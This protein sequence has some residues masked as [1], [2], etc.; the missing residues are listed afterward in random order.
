GDAELPAGDAGLPAG[1][2]ELPAGGAELRGGDAG[3][4]AGD[5]ELVAICAPGGVV[6]D[7]ERCSAKNP[8]DGGRLLR[9]FREAPYKA[10]LYFGFEDKDPAMSVSLSFVRDICERFILEL[11]RDN[12]IEFTRQARP[13]SQ[14]VVDG[15]I[16]GV[17]F[18]TGAELVD[19]EWVRA[20]WAGLAGAFELEIGAWDGDAADFLRQ[21]K[22]GLNVAGRIFFHLV[23]NK[24]EEFPFAFMA[25]YSTG[26]K[27]SRRVNHLPLKG[28]LDE[29]RNDHETLL[30][31]LATISRAAER[32]DFLSSLMESGELFSPLRLTAGDAYTFLRET[33][34]YEECGILCRIPNWWKRRGGSVR[35]AVSF[36]AAEEAK[37]GFDA[38]LRCDPALYF[39][40]DEIS[41]DE[42]VALS[43]Q[44][45]GLSFLKGK[46]VEVDQEKIRLAL[47]AYEKA[48][49]LGD[50]TIAEAMRLELGIDAMP[51]MGAEVDLPQLTNEGWRASLRAR[52]AALGRRGGGAAGAG[53]AAAAGEA[54]GAGEK[55][56]ELSPGDGFKAT[57]RHYQQKG[58][59][60]L[61]A[62]RS[63]G[64]GALLA[65]DMGLGKT[66]Q[67]LALLEYLRQNGGFRGLLILPASLVGNWQ[68]EIERFAPEI[69]YAVLHPSQKRT[70]G[71]DTQ[72]FITTYGMALRL[73]ELGDRV[74]D[75]LILDEAQA[76]KNPGA[77][78]TKAIK[79]IKAAFRVA[80]TGTPVENRLSD[81][82]SLFDFLNAG[83][84]GSV[85]EF[86]RYAGT[87]KETGSYG[88]L[89]EA[90]R[91]FIL[92]RL[93]TDKTIISDLPDKIEIKDYA[94]LTKK[95][96][97][98]YVELVEDI[99]AK[100]ARAEDQAG[101]E[102]KGMVLAAIMKFKQICNHPDQYL[103][104]SEYKEAH[105]G[106]FEKLR[107]I[108]ET[109]AEKREKVIVFTQF[110][111]ITAYLADYL[112]GVFHRP[113]LVIHGGTG[114]KKRME[115]VNRFNSEEYV[116][117]MVLSLKAGG[118]GLNLTAA[119][120]VVHFDRW[121]NPAVENQAT[122]R[123]FRI[124]QTKNVM[125]RKFIAKGTI[126]EK[127]DEM[128]ESKLGLA[129]SLLETSGESWVTE[130][131]DA[132]LLSLFSLD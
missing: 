123:A 62:M 88:K 116:P 18:M 75:L 65:D 56:A 38:I 124:G 127:I 76:I 90:I 28:A 35:V 16:A 114:V 22:A 101:I 66:A 44:S 13:P 91:P 103:G 117:F 42:L 80:M 59:L 83:F 24:S 27:G 92:R 71:D 9:A 100:L 15:I 30:K 19:G 115:Y 39:G 96:R 3:L 40:D 119:S 53:A 86:A 49:A 94:G 81:L 52:L 45:A 55:A 64:F 51:S 70:D 99:R 78:Q 34:D 10:L 121:W 130:M 12:E 120:H 43:R 98:L 25:T 4:P 23:E 68:K 118:V 125:V 29:Y 32:S 58:F 7:E 1:D 57:L 31:L 60:W 33:P 93:K 122:D 113:G 20:F 2:A 61:A 87:I 11:S 77:K 37:V 48:L 126:E 17:P 82:W 102:R 21:H 54:G 5:A 47:A 110:K 132:E 50:L 95:Q 131:S 41:R 128:I 26:D 36:A 84:L 112:A 105:S 46:W 72:L 74:W 109:I 107:E 73:T 89:K 69:K 106:K 108:C 67:V 111:E 14:E 129:N 79:Q 63:M 8:Y 6:L 85:K 104:Q 97:A